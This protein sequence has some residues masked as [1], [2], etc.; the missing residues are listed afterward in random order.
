MEAKQIGNAVMFSN[1]GKSTLADCVQVGF[2]NKV[3]IAGGVF[4]LRS[5][6]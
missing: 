3:Y 4:V 2:I 1:F 5:L 6:V